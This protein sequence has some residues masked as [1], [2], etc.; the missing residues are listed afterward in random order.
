MTGRHVKG[1]KRRKKAPSGL[2]KLLDSGKKIMAVWILVNSTV[3][4]YLSYLLAFKD[5]ADIAESLSSNVVV[6]VIA[7]FATYAASSV[8]EHISESK[9][10]TIQ[11]APKTK[12]ENTE[13]SI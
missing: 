10:G 11:P 4:V 3:W 6:T 12:N 2:R 7:V 5:K 9:H 13:E 8:V 1:R